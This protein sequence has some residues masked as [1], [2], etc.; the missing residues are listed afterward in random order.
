[1][2]DKKLQEFRA[3]QVEIK[4][5]IDRLQKADEEYYIT[6]SYLPWL[7]EPIIL[8]YKERHKWFPLYDVFRH[9]K[10]DI[11]IDLNQI[12]QFFKNSKIPSLCKSYC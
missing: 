4:N 8:S 3:K 1:M 10:D 12:K 6:A 7:I 5:N 9:F 11:K 2:Y